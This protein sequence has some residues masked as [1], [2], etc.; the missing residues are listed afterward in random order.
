M[1]NNPEKRK[2]FEY[3]DGIYLV[4]R[5]Y[6]FTKVSQY[7]FTQKWKKA[8]CNK[9][10]SVIGMDILYSIVMQKNDR[11]L[12][13]RDRIRVD[14]CGDINA[15]LN[16]DKYVIG[17]PIK[18]VIGFTGFSWL[19]LEKLQQNDMEFFAILY[20]QITQEKK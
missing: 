4:M 13:L 15:F 6:K 2:L 11:I 14:F 7:D 19:M 16:A 5:Q 9:G 17:R 18:S 1:S 12:G 10:L 8:K 3:I 20:K